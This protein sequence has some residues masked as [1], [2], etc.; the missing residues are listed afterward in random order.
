VDHGSSRPSAAAGFAVTR[1]S[2]VLSAGR[3]D[4]AG[5]NEAIEELCQTYWRPIYTF[6][7]H[8]GHNPCDAQDLTQEFFARVFSKN[9]LGGVGPS[10]GRFRTFLLA[11]LK[12][13]L[14]NEWDKANAKKRGG[15][16][17]FVS[18]SDRAD[19]TPPPA[20]PVDNQS[21]DVLFDRSW[22]LTLLE[23]VLARLRQEHL[24]D[25]KAEFFEQ[26]KSTL[27]GERT[28]LP[29]S[30][31]GARLGLSE[32]AVKVAVHR[33]RQRYRS[34]LREEIA[35]TVSSPEQIEEEIR[36]LFAALS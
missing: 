35:H 36:A 12:H 20:D 17:V 15:G 29:Y 28:S 22:A 13:F 33:L 11:A 10:K 19:G 7:C 8:R 4:D 30:G 9:C 2:V 31:I 14:A 23:Q 32:G 34:L 16:R 26:L 25:G 18:L 27:T 21:A 3:S 24:R 5:A 6:I 1:W